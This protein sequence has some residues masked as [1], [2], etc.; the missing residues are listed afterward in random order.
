MN[1]WAIC[2]PPVFFLVVPCETGIFW[3]RFF[4]PAQKCGDKEKAKG[5]GLNQPYS[6]QLKGGYP[7]KG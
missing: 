4:D 1:E 6:F 3:G 7:C 5:V 2:F